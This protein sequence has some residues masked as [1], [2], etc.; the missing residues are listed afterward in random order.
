MRWE[1]TCA[2]AYG[3]PVPSRVYSAFVLLWW[4]RG[5]RRLLAGRLASSR[6]SVTS[7]LPH[8]TTEPH[9]MPIFSSTLPTCAACGAFLAPT[10]QEANLLIASTLIATR[11]PLPIRLL[12]RRCV[13]HDPQADPE[14]DEPRLPGT[15]A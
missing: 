7:V 14:A 6:P 1:H 12:C 5:A 11:W 8:A 13:R 4:E 10:E 3:M 15:P 9:A 2:V